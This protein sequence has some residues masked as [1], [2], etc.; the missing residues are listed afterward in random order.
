MRYH[1]FTSQMKKGR[2]AKATELSYE[3]AELRLQSLLDF[4]SQV[5]SK[6]PRKVRFSVIRFLKC[7]VYKLI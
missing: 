2:P 6:E 4:Q 1:Y 5:F 7:N 3:T